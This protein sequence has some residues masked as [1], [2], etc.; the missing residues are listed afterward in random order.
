MS[1][2]YSRMNYSKCAAAAAIGLYCSKAASDVADAEPTPR[3]ELPAGF[4]ELR[5]F[6][7]GP[8][9]V[10]VFRNEAAL[11]VHFVGSN[12][13]ADAEVNLDAELVPSWDLQ[14]LGIE[15]ALVHRG[16]QVAFDIIRSPLLSVVDES[17]GEGS[18]FISGHSMGGALAV[19]AGLA[20]AHH[21]PSLLTFG[22]PRVGDALFSEGVDYIIEDYERIEAAGDV[23]PHLPPS[24]LWFDKYKSAGDML[25]MT[26]DR[27]V[28]R[29]ISLWRRIGESFKSF[30]R[31]KE[32]VLWHHSMAN[33]DKLIKDLLADKGE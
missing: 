5:W 19:L 6:D 14:I 20:M 8:V 15:G 29:Q 33:Y 30:F 22:S 17:I 1:G 12:E 9:Q 18:L 27:R 31:S 28:F 24:L 23:V 25:Y 21:A 2:R 7:A 16:Y 13:A 11:W 4:K 10:C 26:S 32:S 3:P